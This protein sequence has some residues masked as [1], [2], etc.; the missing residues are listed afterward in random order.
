MIRRG[1]I[2]WLSGLVLAALLACSSQDD[3]RAR[4]QSYFFLESLKQVDAGGRQLKNPALDEAGL[5]QS[6]TTLDEGLKL[7]FQVERSFLDE[8]DLRLGKNYERLFIRGV[9][10]YRL[11][12]EAGNQQQ[13]LD[14]LRLLQQWADFWNE[15]RAGV[16]EK[17]PSA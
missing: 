2:V 4:T 3:Q 13:Q 17:L 5:S 8:L 15:A 7:A 12:I 9:E 16:Q 11:G 1:K 14:G 6:L 10:N